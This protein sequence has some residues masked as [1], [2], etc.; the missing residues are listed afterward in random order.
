LFNIVSYFYEVTITCVTDNCWAFVF[1]TEVM[2]GLL[3]SAKA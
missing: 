2:G 3:R 1:T